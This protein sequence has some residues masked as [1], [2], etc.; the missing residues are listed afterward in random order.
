M[1]G[2]IQVNGV[3]ADCVDL[4]VYPRHQVTTVINELLGVLN[5]EF[6]QKWIDAV[7]LWPNIVIPSKY[8]FAGSS[9]FLFDYAI[10][11]I[12]L[13]EFKPQFG[14]VDVFIDKRDYHSLRQFLRD[15]KQIG[16]F[17]CFG[18]SQTSISQISA[19]FKTPIGN[20]QFDFVP[21]D[22]DAACIP[23]EWAIFSHYSDWNDITKGI[24]GVFHKYLLG[25]I[26]F[27][28]S[29]YEYVA[30]CKKGIP[31]YIEVHPH[32]FSVTHGLR[33]KYKVIMENSP[34]LNGRLLG[35][36]SVA[37]SSYTTDLSEIS[38]ILFTT[39]TTKDRMWS[40][41]DLC[42][43]IKYRFPRDEQKKIYDEFVNRC[44]GTN[45]QQLYRDD[46]EKDKAVKMIPITYLKDKLRM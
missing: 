20:I 33:K 26:D 46:E 23:T 19:L 17:E 21:V 15:N 5:A 12:E 40:F 42:E 6:E 2:N 13:A 37:E 9:R 10:A 38:D 35:E 1:G 3:G 45:A 16:S 36:L 7:P 44:I 4:L 39:H 18:I 14:D 43:V 25:S 32:A 41:I 22:C 28:N 30:K 8:R 34:A 24:K 11:N 31:T 29:Q 27:A